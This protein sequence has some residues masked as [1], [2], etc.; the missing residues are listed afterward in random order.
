VADPYLVGIGH[1][2]TSRSRTHHPPSAR[3]AE[4]DYTGVYLTGRG[5]ALSRLVADQDESDRGVPLH[6]KST[7]IT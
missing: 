4:G 3:Y 2:T 5:M 6:F 7:T 1:T